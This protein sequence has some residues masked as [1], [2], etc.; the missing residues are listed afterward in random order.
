MGF[1]S[2]AVQRFDLERF[3]R[4]NGVDVA[5]HLDLGEWQDKDVDQLV[6]HFVESGF[7]ALVCWRID[8][9]PKQ[10]DRLEDLVRFL[11]ALMN[12]KIQFASVAD[13]IDTDM[14]ADIFIEKLNAAWRL[15]KKSRKS[16]NARAS[17]IKAKVRNHKRG[18]KK[19]RNDVLIQDLRNQGFSLRAI[20]QKVGFSTTAV[21]R[22]LKGA[23]NDTSEPQNAEI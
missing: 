11:A 1:E 12:A 9:L 22:A 13:N 5:R 19:L 8:C 3:G 7:K 18:R 14:S 2:P 20:A 10:L 15:L 4:A 16:E 17:S 21:Q 6:R 23:K